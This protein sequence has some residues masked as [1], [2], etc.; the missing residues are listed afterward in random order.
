M[1]WPDLCVQNL[2]A[3]DWWEREPSGVLRPGLLV[4][5]QLPHVDLMPYKLWIDERYA[6]T[7]H[8]KFEGR[9]EQTSVRE[10]RETRSLPVAGLPE[11]DGETSV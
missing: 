2:V 5:A 11:F 7:I 4:H 9:I 10:A 3:G 1:S 6:R 8:T